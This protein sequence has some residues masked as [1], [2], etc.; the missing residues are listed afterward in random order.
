M[1]RGER[2]REIAARVGSLSHIG[3][4]DVA[5][6]GSLQVTE[7]QI[8]DAIGNTSYRTVQEDEI[9]DAGMITAKSPGILALEVGIAGAAAVGIIRSEIDIVAATVDRGV[10]AGAPVRAIST[11]GMQ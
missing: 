7:R 4:D 9:G 6:I 2:R 1:G 5:P 10:R 8:V 11:G 3:R